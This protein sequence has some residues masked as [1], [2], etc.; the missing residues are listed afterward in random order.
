MTAMNEIDG[1]DGAD[2]AE[3]G[4]PLRLARTI[5][6]QAFGSARAND[7]RDP[8]MEPRWQGIRVIAAV[9]GKETLFLEDGVEID[10]PDPIRGALIRT[11]GATTDGAVLD[12][13]LTKLVATSEDDA[14]PLPETDLE[15]IPSV[16]R[17]FMIGTRRDRRAEALKQLAAEEAARTFAEDDPV[18]LVITDLLWLDGEWLLDIPLLERKRL[19]GSIVPSS[20]LI[21]AGAYVRPPLGTWIGS[22]RAQG[23]H[24]ITL[25]EANSRYRPGTEAADWASSSMPR[26]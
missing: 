16:T 14:Q 22:W 19:L 12:G 9:L 7:I 5:R 4:D 2:E 3:R 18:N 15:K 23:F 13:Y 20:D 25:K 24:G 21:R 11:V 1:A 17:S 10:G 8:I 6:P 26:R